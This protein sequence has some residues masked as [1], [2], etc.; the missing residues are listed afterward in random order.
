FLA[1]PVRV[2]VLDNVSTIALLRMR[3]SSLAAVADVFS[4]NPR[5][6]R[7]LSGQKRRKGDVLLFHGDARTAFHVEA[8]PELAPLV[9]TSARARADDEDD[10]PPAAATNGHAYRARQAVEPY[11]VI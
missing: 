10:E 9:S 3:A 6:V 1:D 7:F 4:L 11:R 8:S 5:E 2:A